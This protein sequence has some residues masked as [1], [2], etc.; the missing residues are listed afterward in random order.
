M[1]VSREILGLSKRYP[2]VPFETSFDGQRTFSDFVEDDTGQAVVVGNSH[3]RDIGT[4]SGTS[5]VNGSHGYQAAAWPSGLSID[6]SQGI[7]SEL[8]DLFPQWNSDD[9]FRFSEPDAGS[10]PDRDEGADGWRAGDPATTTSSWSAAAGAQ[11]EVPSAQLWHPLMSGDAGS[12]LLLP[13]SSVGQQMDADLPHAA[14]VGLPAPVSALADLGQDSFPLAVASAVDAGSGTT[15]AGAAKPVG[16]IPQLADYL[17]TGF[18]QFNATIAH[19]WASTTI[20]YNI[21]GLTSAEQFLAQSAFEAW[22]EVTN[23][24]F[25]PTTGAANITFNHNGSMTAFE[26]DSYDSAGIMSSATVDISADWITTDGG[27][28]DGNTG[29]DSYGYQT[30]IH[31]IGHALGLGHQGPYN[32]SASYS[33][34]AT[35]ADDT[36]QYSVMSYFSENNYNGGSYRYV[37]TPQMADIY[38]VDSIYGAA[39]TRTGDTVYGFHDTAGSIYNFAS[40]AQ[41]P[42]LT[43]YDSGGYDTLDC[44]GYS[45]AQTIDLHAGAFSSVGGLVHNIGIAANT[46]IENAIGGSGNDT[47]IANDNGCTLQGGAGNDILIAGG[48]R[49]TLTGGAG[50]DIFVFNSATAASGPHDLI[51]DFVSGTDKIDLSGF[52]ALPDDPAIDP[53]FFL[54]AAGFSGSAGVLDYRFDSSRDVTV[55]QGDKNGDSI[56]DFAID[57]SGNV[58]PT[59]SDLIG[60]ITTKTVIDAYGSTDLTQAGNRFYFYDSTGSGPSLK[61]GGADVIAGQFAGWTLIGGEQTASGYEAAWKMSGADQYMVWNTDSNG[62]FVSQTPVVSGASASLMS[63]EPSFHQDLNGDGKIGAPAPA[64]TAIESYGSTDMTQV[65]SHFYFYDSAGS[66]PS[67]KYGGADVV[68][69]QFGAWTLIGGEQTASGYEAAWKMSGADQYTVWN[70]DSNGNYVSQTSVV[71]GASVTL[72]SLE[73]SFHQDL[74]GDGQIGTSTH[75]QTGTAIEAYG[76]TDMTQVGSHFYFYD[77]T[78]SGPSLKYGGADVAA[79]EFGGWTLIGGEQT[80]S[81][82]EAAWKMSGADQYTVW[83]TD[84]NGNYVSQT[85]VVSGASATLTSLETSFHQDLNGDGHIGASAS[86][87]TAIVIE[88]YGSTDLTQA[89][90]RFYF[91]DSAGSGPSLKYGGADV[92][93][94][95]FAGWT[96]IGGEQTAGGYEAA[97]KMSGAD[98]YT[99]W[100]TDS[101]GNYVSQTPVVSGASATL[102]S[103]ESSFHQDLNG[104]G[105]IAAAM[106]TANNLHQHADW[107][108]V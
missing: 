4:E 73:S 44:S 1:R 95:Q 51:T 96:L 15:S 17:V 13:S 82:Y 107:M 61:Y 103:L 3:T 29:I 24:T 28:L 98:Q 19:H 85:P 63:L 88:A 86:S 41:A 36:W 97:W 69:G 21:D 39:T 53:W 89:G 31:E 83:N 72:T 99:V 68:A 108:L 92:V 71:S 45:V 75:N 80:A 14:D 62:N 101:N 22:H 102:T 40:Y 52:D 70:T 50:A 42:A 79:D 67:L 60:I 27:A 87:Q 43:I 93:A 9:V 91:Y 2:W 105:V 32:G 48:G 64:Q 47:L 20:S 5:D 49:D 77:S 59:A 18:W 33:T 38:A 74:N 30:Y 35:Y 34:G 94:G 46:D 8:S 12:D 54:G 23:L 25:V 106:T 104:D 90:N 16:T 55:L 10:A 76:S 6:S 56:A 58:T 37:V 26:T 7:Q 11:T 66:G 78:G 81:G 57:L 65:G 84:S 100:N